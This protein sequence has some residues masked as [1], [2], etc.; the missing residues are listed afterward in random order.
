MT[1]DKN[2]NLFIQW[3]NIIIPDGILVIIFM[4]PRKALFPQSLY[5]PGGFLSKATCFLMNP[6]LMSNC[7]SNYV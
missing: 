7:D 2:I 5:V 1:E 4:I 3:L 6:D